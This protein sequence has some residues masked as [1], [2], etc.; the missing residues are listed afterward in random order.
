[1]VIVDHNTATTIH[2]DKIIAIISIIIIGFVN[3]RGVSETGKAGTIVT[4]VQLGSILSIILA[5]LWA[6]NTHPYWTS[7]FKDF[8]PNGFN[9]LAAAMGLLFIA[10]E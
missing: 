8:L 4:I 5:G 10:F 3:I 1:M 2:L 6:M 9:G 7:N